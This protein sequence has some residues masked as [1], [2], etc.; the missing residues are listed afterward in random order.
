MHATAATQ[1][2]VASAASTRFRDSTR[3][4]ECATRIRA[5]KQA[6]GHAVNETRTARDHLNHAHKLMTQIRTT[7]HQIECATR[8]QAS[9]RARRK[10]YPHRP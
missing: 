8:I 7:Y 3:A 5:S 2:R 1:L 9:E 4:F 10:R 6:K